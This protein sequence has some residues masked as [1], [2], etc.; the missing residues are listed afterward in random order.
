VGK[1]SFPQGHVRG[2]VYEKRD[3]LP[4]NGVRAS[5]FGVRT[6][7]RVLL[8]GLL[9]FQLGPACGFANAAAMPSMECCRTKCPTRSSRTP[10]TCC[11]ISVSPDKAKPSTTSAPQGAFAFQI[12]FLAPVVVEKFSNLSFIIYRSPAPPPHRMRLDLF[13]SRQ[14]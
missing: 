10:A 6:L 11:R 14:I 9:V 1:I 8:L 13:C 3:K 12:G 4:A 7:V 2:A 5:V